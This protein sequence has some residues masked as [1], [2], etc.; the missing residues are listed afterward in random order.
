MDEDGQGLRVLYKGLGRVSLTDLSKTHTVSILARRQTTCE[1]HRGST[2]RRDDSPAYIEFEVILMSK[3]CCATLSLSPS[4][5]DVCSRSLVQKQGVAVPSL[6]GT[7]MSA[8]VPI[9]SEG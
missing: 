9:E 2:S 7:C 5:S 4:P 6:C 3:S 1:R 8:T